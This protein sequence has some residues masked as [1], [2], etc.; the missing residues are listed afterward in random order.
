MQAGDLV[1]VREQGLIPDVIRYFDKGKFNH[2]AIAMDS[3]HILEAEYNTKVHVIENPYTDIEV[4]SLNLKDLSKIEEFVK[5]YDGE[6]YDFG[7]VLRIFIRLELHIDFFNKFNDT[8]EV[9]C[10]ELAGDWLELIGI[11]KK[12]EE[13]LAPN[14]LYRSIKSMGY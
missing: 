2:V 11:T 8:K 4:V 9:I 1:F 13:L 10:S 7:E 14:E 5:Q 6:E 12:G 3:T